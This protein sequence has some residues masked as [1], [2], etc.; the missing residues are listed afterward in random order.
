M[1]HVLTFSCIK[2]NGIAEPSSLNPLPVRQ[3]RK[4]PTADGTHHAPVE[5]HFLGF[6]KAFASSSSSSRYYEFIMSAF[7]NDFL[8]ASVLTDL[9]K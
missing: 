2:S 5:E 6:H 1:Q 3:K 9:A 7:A 8:N 4:S